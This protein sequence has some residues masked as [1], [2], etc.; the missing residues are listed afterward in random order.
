MVHGNAVRDQLSLYRFRF[1]DCWMFDALIMFL[2]NTHIMH[3]IPHDVVYLVQLVHAN[4]GY[5]FREIEAM[6][7]RL[8][9]QGEYN[10]L[11][12]ASTQH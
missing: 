6:L 10:M 5:S 7:A 3:S 1:R 12:D 8:R 2:N 4:E 11:E 9:D